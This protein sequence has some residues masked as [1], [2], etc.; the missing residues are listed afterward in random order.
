MTI[1]QELTMFDFIRQRFA[2]TK[3]SDEER[4]FITQIANSEIWILAVGLRGVPQ[5]SGVFDD[6]ALDIITAHRIDVWEAGDEDSVWPFNYQR[7]GRHTLPFFGSRQHAREFAAKTLPAGT[8]TGVFQPYELLA[9]FVSS[10]ENEV[11]NLV[12]QLGFAEE[13]ALTEPGRKLLRSLA[14]A[15]G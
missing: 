13:R 2:T 1:S 5:I 7:D 3:I 9:G 12:F 11:F 10:P 15:N 8:E 14:V 4:A 6:A